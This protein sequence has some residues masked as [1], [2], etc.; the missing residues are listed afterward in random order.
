MRITS[1]EFQ[2]GDSRNLLIYRILL[3]AENSCLGPLFQRAGFAEGVKLC[4]AVGVDEGGE[5]TVE[6]ASDRAGVVED[7]ALSVFLSVR[8]PFGEAS[9]VG[10]AGVGEI[11]PGL[12]HIL[13]HL[14]VGVGGSGTVVF[15]QL[16]GIEAE[17][18]FGSVG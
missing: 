18:Q 16:Q 4:E 3:S 13:C 12:G 10:I 6:V 14:T 2:G 11:G 7:E 9:H 5:G 8:M 17:V 15:R 1:Q